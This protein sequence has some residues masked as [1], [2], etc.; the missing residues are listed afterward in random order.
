MP[1]LQDDRP[2]WTGA[3]GFHPDAPEVGDGRIPNSMRAGSKNVWLQVGG[4][5]ESARGL[6]APTG[7]ANNRLYLVGS[8]IGSLTLGSVILYSNASYWFSG[9]GTVRVAGA[10][11][12]TASSTLQFYLQSNSTVYVA[13]LAAPSTKPLILESVTTG[14]NTGSYAVQLTRKRSQTQAESNPTPPSE[15]ITVSGKKITITFPG[16]LFGQDLWVI[17]ATVAGLGQEG[18][19]LKLQEVMIGGGAGQV[20]AGGGT[21]DFDWLNSELG[22]TLPPTDHNPPSSGLFCAS[23]NDCMLNF[24]VSGTDIQVSTPGDPESYPA[25]FT[26]ITTPPETPIGVATRP[27]ENELMFWC[28]NSV[29]SLVY[30]G[31]TFGPVFIR[32]R[33]PIAGCLGPQAATWGQDEFHLNSNGGPVRIKNNQVDTTFAVDVQRFI[34]NLNFDPALV[35]LGY[36]QLFDAV[37]YCYGTTALPWMRQQQ[38]WGA[39]ILLSG[40]PDAAV[41]QSG[42][43]FLSIGGKFQE[44]E[45]GTG[46]TYKVNTS[47][48]D[49]GIPSDEKTYRG[50][51]AI[52]DSDVET[53][54]IKTYRNLD[55]TT[56][57]DNTTIAAGAAG[58]K[59]TKWTEKNSAAFQWS[60]EL[61]G[62]SK[63]SKNHRILLL[64]SAYLY[65]PGVL[66]N[67]RL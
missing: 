54:N 12:G 35:V 1:E 65:E 38:Q 26:Q 10:T 14:R 49:A 63:D 60:Y 42:K 59:R 50:V 44:W 19:F 47:H 32:A 9:S 55:L 56:P 34:R 66:S 51:Q 61:N 23:L 17:Y 67:E 36:A 24:G 29:Q 28:A 11:I 30:T 40:V 31:D 21:L 53:F 6:G 22:A 48:E 13:G 58:V 2:T 64:T 4:I 62:T 5:L 15:A 16:A 7:T 39:P 27:N 20:S 45:G 37:I 57:I 41:T 25:R 46:T 8:D 3:N 18:P 33:W 52:V 43:L